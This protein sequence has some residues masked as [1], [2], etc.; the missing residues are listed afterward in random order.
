MPP[1]FY[2]K[3]NYL[4]LRLN[5]NAIANSPSSAAKAEGSGTTTNCKLFPLHWRK[6][7]SPNIADMES[8]VEE[9]ISFDESE[10]LK[11]LR[12]SALMMLN[13]PYIPSSYPTLLKSK[14]SCVL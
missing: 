13:V 1:S 10:V 11:P 6:V 2:R 4:I 3:K 9:E 14:Y 5:A 8:K 12:E 7:S